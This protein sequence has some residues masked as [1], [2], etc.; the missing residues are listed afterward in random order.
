MPVIN[1]KCENYCTRVRLAEYILCMHNPTLQVT[2][3][4]QVVG[5]S[6]GANVA[7]AFNTNCFKDPT[8]TSHI[9]FRAKY[10]SSSTPYSY[11]W[12]TLVY[13]TLV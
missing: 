13:Y 12:I 10:Q 8:T 4:K 3:E 7:Q 1:I 6:L 11:P 9:C 2:L 5:F